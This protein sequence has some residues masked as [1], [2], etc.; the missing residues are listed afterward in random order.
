MRLKNLRPQYIYRQQQTRERERERERAVVTINREQEL[1]ECLPFVVI[2]EKYKQRSY[3]V[4]FVEQ[5]RIATM[6]LG[7]WPSAEAYRFNAIGAILTCST[8]ITMSLR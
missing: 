5:A 4:T 8:K 3:I 2:I 1:V 7:K 6:A